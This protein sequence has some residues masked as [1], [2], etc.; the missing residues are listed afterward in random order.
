M[1]SSGARRSHVRRST[2]ARGS[3]VDRAPFEKLHVVRRAPLRSDGA[4]RDPAI[5]VVARLVA[6]AS[7]S[8]ARTAAPNRGAVR[9]EAPPGRATR[10]RFGNASSRRLGLHVVGLVA[11]H[12]GC[13][14]GAPDTDG[15]VV[16]RTKTSRERASADE[17][18]HCAARLD[19]RYLGRCDAGDERGAS[20]AAACATVDTAA[21][22]EKSL[23]HR[24]ADDAKGSRHVR[25]EA[26]GGYVAD[27][28]IA[29]GSF[30][31]I[32]GFC[33]GD[34]GACGRRLQCRG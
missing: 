8:S 32:A 17:C 1:R 5:L 14:V 10:R 21:S 25:R 12:Q 3:G 16:H 20:R 13:R 19:R 22:G 23:F 28:R 7:A 6:R 29:R 27:D 34:E 15:D 31:G 9:R 26:S 33:R 11:T 24:D 4:P 18:A 30:A 2:R